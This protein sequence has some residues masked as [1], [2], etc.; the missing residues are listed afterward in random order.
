MPRHPV[1]RVRTAAQ[2]RTTTLLK[3]LL[4]QPPATDQPQVTWTSATV[5]WYDAT[6]TVELT[7]R[8]SL[9]PLGQTHS[10][11]ADPRAFAPQALRA[12]ARS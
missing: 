2:R 4:E 5:G 8:P 9:V 7:S 10:L 11:G 1:N 6:R 12:R 3:A